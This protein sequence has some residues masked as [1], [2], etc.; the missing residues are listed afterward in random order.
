MIK[1]FNPISQEA[2]PMNQFNKDLIAAL[3]QKQDLSEVF[4]HYLEQAVNDLL[5]HELAAFLGYEPYARQGFNSGNSRNGS[6][7]RT[8]ISHCNF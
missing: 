1:V 3:V 8:L 7:Q 4:R 2:S 5:Q 6:Y